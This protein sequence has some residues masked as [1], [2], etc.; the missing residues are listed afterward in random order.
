MGFYNQFALYCWNFRNNTTYI[1]YFIIISAI[2]S[3]IGSFIYYIYFYQD[4]DLDE[5]V[6]VFFMSILTSILGA[7]IG[8]LIAVSWSILVAYI[9]PL[10]LISYGIYRGKDIIDFFK[11]KKTN[12]Q[13][14]QS[15]NIIKETINEIK[16]EEIAKQA[17]E[18]LRKDFPDIKYESV[19]ANI[20]SKL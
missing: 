16:C 5:F 18:N 9:L 14:K 17:Y 7:L 3:F 12:S 15:K 8:I 11:N 2:V 13:K 20:K 4:D 6:H 19:L 10:I 1:I